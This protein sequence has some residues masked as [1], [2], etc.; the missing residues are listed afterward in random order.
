[1]VFF[2]GIHV[3]IFLTD[4]LSAK[5]QMEFARLDAPSPTAIWGIRREDPNPFPFWKN[6]WYPQMF[7]GGQSA[8]PK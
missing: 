6:V 7:Q 8:L 2:A 3:V 5:G 1:M 4:D